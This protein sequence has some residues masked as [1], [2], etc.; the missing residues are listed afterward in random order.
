MRF[1]LTRCRWWW[2]GCRW[3][4]MHCKITV[5]VRNSKFLQ[6]LFLILLLPVH[7]FSLSFSHLFV[8]WHSPTVSM[9][10]RVREKRRA[11]FHGLVFIYT[12]ATHKDLSHTRERRREGT[13]ERIPNSDMHADWIVWDFIHLFCA[14]VL[15]C[16]SS[17]DR[18][19]NWRESERTTTENVVHMIC[20]PIVLRKYEAKGYERL[21]KEFLPVC[22]I[23]LFQLPSSSFVRFPAIL[24]DAFITSEQNKTKT[25]W[26]MCVC[27]RLSL[28]G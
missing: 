4:R 17:P 5:R 20:L 15:K 25:D 6:L 18:N 12:F 11:D 13:T 3:W 1:N 27:L 22:T 9:K 24:S 26:R 10:H 2:W 23:S 14:A 7:S 16:L 8:H 19:T 28:T 21:R